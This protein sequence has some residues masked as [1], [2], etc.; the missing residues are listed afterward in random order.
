[1]SL[2]PPRGCR[3]FVMDVADTVATLH[4]SYTP[5]AWEHQQHAVEVWL[6]R[7][8]ATSPWRVSSVADADMIFLANAG[9]SRWC[10][11]SR[12]L[13]M[14]YRAAGKAG[15]IGELEPVC[16]DQT[17]GPPPP[18]R[19]QQHVGPR[20]RGH[21]PAWARQGLVLEAKQLMRDEQSKRWLWRKM[22]AHSE[23]LQREAV[24]ARGGGGDGSAA[25][26]PRVLTLTSHE[27][28]RPYHGGG[29]GGGKAGG[30]KAASN[31]PRPRDLVA[32]ADK[33]ERPQDRLV[34]YV[35]SR[36]AWLVGDAAPPYV[37]VAWE[38][39][40]LLFMSGHVPKLFNSAVR[41]LLWKGL[42]ASPHLATV[43]SSTIGCNIGAYNVC[44]AP[45]RVDAEAATFCRD[46]CRGDGQNGG[47][48]QYLSKCTASAAALRRMCT[49]PSRGYLAQVDYG[50]EADALLA[51]SRQ[52]R[53]SHAAYL[54]L[55]MSH[56]FCVV[57]PGDF[58]ATH[59]VAEAM[60]LGGAGGC[61]PLFVV[62]PK[63][64][65]AELLPYI[66]WLDYCAVSV[67]VAEDDATRR[68]PAVLRALQALPA[69]EIAAKRETLRSVRD[70]FVVRARSSPQ[71][72][73]AAEYV[74]AEACA[75][76]RGLRGQANRSRRAATGGRRGGGG[77]GGGGGGADEE[78]G[79]VAAA[80]RRL[81]RCFL[82]VTN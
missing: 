28:P 38:A 1:M 11:A 75:A 34:P 6:S 65:A 82:K 40:K 76:A 31:P 39:R 55:G 49:R 41:Y 33:L 24:A 48:S 61:L 47:G 9:F 58:V 74:L 14:R 42:H 30:K 71:R 46:W 73:S 44:T 77:H 4:P 51:A 8:L 81:S 70:A 18:P 52:P 57:A 17:S 21:R 32:L 7:A 23:A 80:I 63:G 43:R 66:R 2:P 53:L 3:I 37:P 50:R 62:P 15:R 19:P 64:D 45:A 13:Q 59:K 69:A 72:P 35:V 27:C 78:G 36:P 79:G 22:L 54:G 10:T 5:C 16:I 20:G 68:M 56:R 29:G 60:A 67:L 26:P 25:P 12:V